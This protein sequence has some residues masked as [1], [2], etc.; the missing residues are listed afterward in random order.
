MGQCFERI[1]R[2]MMHVLQNCWNVSVCVS[3]SW[4]MACNSARLA[5]RHRNGSEQP[6]RLGYGRDH[7]DWTVGSTDRAKTATTSNDAQKKN[8]PATEVGPPSLLPCLPASLPPCL[9]ASLPPCLPASLPPYLPTSL[10]PYLPTSLPPYLPTSLPPY[11][12][13]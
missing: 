1:G 4:I 5:E 6:R 12:D 3:A 8:E 11:V 10:P 13:E 7:A 2:R 9:P